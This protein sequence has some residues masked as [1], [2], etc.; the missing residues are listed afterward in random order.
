MEAEIGT[1]LADSA[2]AEPPKY[3]TSTPK[4]FERWANAAGMTAAPQ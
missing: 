2:E 1:I 4:S 3:L